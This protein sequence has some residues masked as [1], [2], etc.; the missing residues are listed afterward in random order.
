MAQGMQWPHA[1]RNY[2][3]KLKLR[4]QHVTG[5][6]T[7]MTANLKQSRAENMINSDIIPRLYKLRRAVPNRH[8]V[9]NI[10]LPI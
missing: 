1:I 3:R 10:D 2:M 9:N 4:Y 7:A 6:I 5:S 8:F